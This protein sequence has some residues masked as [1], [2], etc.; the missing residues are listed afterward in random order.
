MNV[1]LEEPGTRRNNAQD[2]LN[3]RIEKE[4]KLKRAGRISLYVDIINALG[5]KYRSII[6]NDGG[7]WF[8]GGENTT[9][10]TRILSSDYKR[11]V[12]VTGVRTF[13]LSLN[14]RF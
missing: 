12:A 11:I 3:L 4:F 10:G 13:R 1:L 7:F 5:N 2:N 14:F 8:P 6:Q 9:E